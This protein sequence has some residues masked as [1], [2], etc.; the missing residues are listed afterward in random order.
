M[1][2]TILA[3]LLL[4]LF[5]PACKKYQYG[6]YFSLATKKQRIEGT[7]RVDSAITPQ[8]VD[9]GG[10]FASY[11]FNFQNGGDARIDFISGI[12]GQAD[13]LFGE[14][15]LEEE[16]DLFAWRDLVG[17][18]TGFYYFRNEMFDILRLTGQEFWLAD[19]DN[20]YLYLSQ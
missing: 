7:W 5:L 3:F 1:K 12:S 13:T 16:R 15:S 6:P 4:I 20:T 2:N 18:T 17:D 14:W 11:R 8:G 19:K 10:A 9:I